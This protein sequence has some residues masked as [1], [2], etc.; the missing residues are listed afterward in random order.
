MQELGRI[1]LLDESI[2]EQKKSLENASLK[3]LME[4]ILKSLELNLNATMVFYFMK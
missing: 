3:I 2:F 1:A 4:Y